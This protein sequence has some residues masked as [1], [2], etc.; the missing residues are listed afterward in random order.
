MTR[1]AWTLLLELAPSVPVDE[2]GLARARSHVEARR[3]GVDDLAYRRRRRALGVRRLTAAAGVAAVAAVV[4]PLG[5]NGDGDGPST[6]VPQALGVLPAAAVG[7]GCTNEDL[8]VPGLSD[9]DQPVP[10]DLWGSVPQ[11]RESLYLV[12]DRTPETAHVTSG[13][14]VCDAIPV[15]VLHDEVGRRGVVVYRDV[16]QAFRG[17]TN[18]GRTTVRG[19]AAQVLSPP[20][21]H[22]FVSW[23]DDEGIRWFTEA[24]GVS[25]EELV[26]ILDTSL[27][28]DGLVATPEGF[29]S[30][31][32]H[33]PDPEGTVYRWTVQYESGGYLYLEVTTPAR[34]AVE[35]RASWATEQ[36][37]TTVGDVR[38]VYLP[39]EQGGAGLRW[40]TDEASYRLVVAGA[41]LAELQEIATSLEHVSPDDPRLPRP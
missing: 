15:A 8:P 2:A 25:V 18:L 10:R 9:P 20:A 34:G 28:D 12:G 21:G 37:Y 35:M 29:R 7:M 38:A 16:T 32:V 41:D 6:G 27:D 1:D 14:A 40:T 30:V 4:W 23:T 5:G 13:P 24:A 36:Q 11:V 19:H 26:G 17:A 3:A 33:A 31:P 39:Q 22:H